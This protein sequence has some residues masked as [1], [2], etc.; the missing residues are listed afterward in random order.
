[1]LNL[2]FAV[3]EIDTD[4]LALKLHNG[5]R[6]VFG[7]LAVIILSSLIVTASDQGGGLLPI[8]LVVVFTLIALYNESWYFHKSDGVIKHLHGLVMLS[9]STTFAAEDVESVEVKSFRKGSVSSQPGQKKRFFQRDLLTLSLIFSEGGKKDI[10]I[11]E[12]KNKTA[13]QRKAA[14]ISDF[15]NISYHSEA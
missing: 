9:A 2:T 11:T 3:K 14:A 12:A 6:I 13:L 4:T 10:E 1:M 7:V 15:M 8:I 5:F